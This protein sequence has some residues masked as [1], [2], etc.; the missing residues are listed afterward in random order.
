M[1]GVR[2]HLVWVFEK[3]EK[4]STFCF[5]LFFDT[6]YFYVYVRMKVSFRD[7]RVLLSVSSIRNH[8]GSILPH[9]PK[10]RS[11]TGCWVETYGSRD[12]RRATGRGYVTD[13]GSSEPPNVWNGL[14]PPSF[15]LHL[16]LVGQL[17][18]YT[19]SLWYVSRNDGVNGDPS[20]RFLSSTLLFVLMTQTVSVPRSSRTDTVARLYFRIQRTPWQDSH[21]TLYW[22]NKK[23][24]RE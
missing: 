4:F 11:V 15:W 12:P 13:V 9:T 22:G 5:V 16:I 24:Y 7:V 10:F 23:C 6:P 21:D 2:S 14:L 8:S 19:R 17:W 1:V 20:P 18:R 3:F